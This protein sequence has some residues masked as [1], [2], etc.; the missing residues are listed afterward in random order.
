MPQFEP[1]YFASQLF[2]L[3]V[4]FALLF[5][6]LSIFA[7]PKIGGIIEDRRKRIDGDLDRAAQCKTEAEAL[8]S[9]YQKALADARAEAHKI[10]QAGAAAIAH[11]AE[12]RQKALSEKLS[13]E[14]KAGE[15]RIHE[16]KDQALTQIRTVS[17]E[18][19]GLTLQKLTGQSADDGQIT[20]AVAAS[21]GG[22]G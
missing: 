21:V 6:L 9:A 7:L 1:T 11:Q 22:R 2:W 19:V 5:L 16:A 18:L 8:I 13:V 20:A 12:A 14:I 15:A 4:S 3:Y 17:G 10:I